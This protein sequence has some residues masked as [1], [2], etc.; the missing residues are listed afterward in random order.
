[1]VTAP[2]VVTLKIAY[3]LQV[4]VAEYAVPVAQRLPSGPATRSPTFPLVESDTSF[5]TWPVI[6]ILVRRSDGA[7]VDEPE[8]VVAAS[9]NPTGIGTA[10]AAGYANLANGVAGWVNSEK[11]IRDPS[12]ITV[13][14]AAG[15]PESAIGARGDV[16]RIRG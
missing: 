15:E 4:Q 8:V 6:E 11:I 16:H 5:R 14:V 2:A 3:L 1:M 7:L 9:H 12:G 13:G 10:C